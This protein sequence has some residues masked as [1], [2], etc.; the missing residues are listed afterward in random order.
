MCG[1]FLIDSSLDDIL[2]AYNIS[3]RNTIKENLDIS[4]GEIFPTM[5]VPVIINNNGLK[6][7]AFNWGFKY[8]STKKNIINARVET[9]SEKPMFRKSYLERRCIIPANAFYEWKTDNDNKIKHKISLKNNKI[10]S[11]AGIY[12]FFNH[13]KDKPYIGFVIITKEANYEMSKI[14]HRMPVILDE[15][16]QNIWLSNEKFNGEKTNEL[17]S[18][19]RN[20]ILNLEADSGVKQ[21]SF[22]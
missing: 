7:E 2:S 5:K 12:N 6:L 20:D 15:T 21:V 8:G 16:L 9:I 11:F 1:R 22:W 17:I 10:M 4:K 14:H 3:N 18:I 13:G 19:N